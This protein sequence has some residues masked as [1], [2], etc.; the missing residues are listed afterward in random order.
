M[1][2]GLS[3]A[4]LIERIKLQQMLKAMDKSMV[5]EQEAGTSWQNMP[6]PSNLPDYK[7]IAEPWNPNTVVPIVAE[8]HRPGDV[9][10]R[11]MYGGD[12]GN[13]RPVPMPTYPPEG[14]VPTGPP[15]V[16]MPSM[17]KIT[18]P[19][20]WMGRWYNE[21]EWEALQ[22]RMREHRQRQSERYSKKWGLP[23]QLL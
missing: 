6:L 17:P 2:K 8:P 21:Q 1:A 10:P 12:W 9:Y 14:W 19:H 22:K 20:K 4:D 15:S 13:A 18:F 3:I 16:E 23:I 7:E 5:T 11:E